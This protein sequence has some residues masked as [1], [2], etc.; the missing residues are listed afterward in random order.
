MHLQLS[1]ASG[2]VRANALLGWETTD[3]SATEMVVRMARRILDLFS[4]YH[5]TEFAKT[6]VVRSR[7]R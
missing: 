5:T 2:T 6:D 7:A 1:A 4:Y 3:T